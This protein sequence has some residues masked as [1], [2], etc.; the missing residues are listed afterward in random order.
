MLR[1]NDQFI[2]LL[3]S[4]LLSPDFPCV[5]AEKRATIRDDKTDLSLLL[6]TLVA[7][8]DYR[9][10]FHDG[11]KKNSSNLSSSSTKKLYAVERSIA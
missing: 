5:A 7:D 4:L 2:T 9:G 3:R 11:V 6:P 8:R 10:R 1:G